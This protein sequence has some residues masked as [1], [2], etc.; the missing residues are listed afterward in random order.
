MFPF[1]SYTYDVVPLSGFEDDISRDD[2]L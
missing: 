2:V 1:A